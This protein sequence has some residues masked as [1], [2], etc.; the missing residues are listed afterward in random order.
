MCKYRLLDHGTPAMSR[1]DC[2]ILKPWRENRSRL[3]IS[4]AAVGLIPA[5]MARSRRPLSIR[6]RGLGKG[7]AGNRA[8]GTSSDLEMFDATADR[9]G[10]TRH[11]RGCFRHGLVASRSGG[12]TKFIAI[13][14]RIQAQRDDVGLSVGSG[15]GRL[16]EIDPS[17]WV[18][19]FPDDS[20]VVLS[21]C[22]PDR[23]LSR[24]HRNSPR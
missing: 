8:S 5:R 13:A 24:D 15:R 22:R 17:I 7:S 19:V 23:Y 3:W 10:R 2:T 1:D 21:L 4:S 18:R 6:H 12:K 16:N 9:S 20:R 11:R 14:Q